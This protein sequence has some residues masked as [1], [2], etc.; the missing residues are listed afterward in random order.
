M[1]RSGNEA[2][3]YNDSSTPKYHVRSAIRVNDNDGA[4]G[5]ISGYG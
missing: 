4:E 2:N 5:E 1:R 3:I